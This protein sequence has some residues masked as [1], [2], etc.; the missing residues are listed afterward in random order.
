MQRLTI[1]NVGPVKEV[2]IKIDN[3][4]VF[5]GP[6]AGGK[7]IICR[8]IFFFRNIKEDLYNFIVELF[9]NTQ[10]IGLFKRFEKIF[11][12]KFYEYWEENFSNYSTLYYEY[13][14]E[15]SLRILIEN[16]ALRLL[17]SN[18]LEQAITAIFEEVIYFKSKRSQ[19]GVSDKN[20]ER[21]EQSR[22]LA[23]MSVAISDLLDHHS[24]QTYIPAGRNVFSVLSSQFNN[25]VSGK[26]DLLKRF[27]NQVLELQPSYAHGLDS[28]A[29]EKLRSAQSAAE[30]GAIVYAKETISK[31]LKGSYKK[32]NNIEKFF[33]DENASLKITSASAGQ[34][35][36][37]WMLNFIF[38]RILNKKNELLI[39][40]EPE[41]FLF[42]ASQKYVVDLL[43]LLY[44]T[45]S[46]QIILTT[47]SPYVLS[48]LNNLLYANKLVKKNRQKVFEILEQNILIPGGTFSAYFVEGGTL[49]SISN[50]ES[51]LIDTYA[52][53]SASRIINEIFY[54][55]FEIDE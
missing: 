10:E 3:F 2:D 14:K 55:L 54:K 38:D 52:I 18:K 27:Y 21:L 41:A 36:N 43:A 16:G 24:S 39:V 48:A 37:V 5:A 49:K 28:L 7:S 33:V 15:A 6:Q 23:E 22:F 29:A 31:I 32:E 46:N 4:M 30:A 35:A 13:T 1:I 19:T 47:H 11:S 9:N 50:V 34:Q 12:D 53:D 17:F 26:Y 45:A 51:G 20:D 25:V 42:P 8:S 44:N 40:E